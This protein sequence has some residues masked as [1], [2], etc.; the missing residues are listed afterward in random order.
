MHLR[1]N[2]FLVLLLVSGPLTARAAPVPQRNSAWSLGLTLLKQDLSY[3]RQSIY[4]GTSGT[5]KV[6]KGYFW[7]KW[8]AGMSIDILAGPHNSPENQ[9]VDVDFSGTGF[10]SYLGYLVLGE[11]LQSNQTGIGVLWT[12]SYSDIIGRSVGTQIES[13]NNPDPINGWVMRVNNFSGGPSLFA[14]WIKSPRKAGETPELLMTRLEGMILQVGMHSPFLTK[15][16]LKYDS[17]SGSQSIRG[18]LDGQTYFI[19]LDFL[20]GS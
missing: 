19:S 4:H 10:S 7:N 5:I 6:G 9:D 15:F 17:L 14:S 18:Q 20:F 11:R 16:N 13:A 12:F 8:M 3:L 1:N 2:K